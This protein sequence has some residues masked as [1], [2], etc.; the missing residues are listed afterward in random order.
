[1]PCL[2]TIAALR[3]EI[4]NWRRSGQSIALVPTMGNLHRG[5]LQLVKKARAAADRLV[6]TIFVNP[7]QFSA[8]EDFDRYPRTLEADLALLQKAGVDLVFAPTEAELYPNGR[9]GLIRLQVSGLGDDLC[10]RTRPG[11]FNGVATVVA[12]LFNLV[13]PDMAFFGHKDYQQ[14]LVIERLVADLNFPVQVIG[15][16]TVRE[17]DGLALS[18]RNQYLSPA[19][20]ALAPQL[21]QTLDDLAVQFK[22]GGQVPELLPRAISHLKALGFR[23]DYLELRRALDLGL[24]NALGFADNQPLVL[25]VAAWLGTTRLIDNLAFSLPDTRT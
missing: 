23:P 8:G 3:K 10:G 4:S 6:V 25:L 12:K 5:H 16:D 19:E 1:M 20:R 17:T 18:S 13:Q 15:L 22:S 24:P 14:L 9:D 11:H 2:T 21:Y 7:L